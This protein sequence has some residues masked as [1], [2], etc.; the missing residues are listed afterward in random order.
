MRPTESRLVRH[1]EM[2]IVDSDSGAND[3]EASGPGVRAKD[4]ILF[5]LSLSS[6]IP[7]PLSLPVYRL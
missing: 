7:S 1:R 6:T 2:T 4:F 3:H 5:I